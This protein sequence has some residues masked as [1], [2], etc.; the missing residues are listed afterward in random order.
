MPKGLRSFD[1][2]DA[3]FFL[4][5]L[6]GPTD[7]EG[8]P[9]SIR[10]W[11]TRLEQTDADATCAVGLVYGPSGCGKS[12]LFKAGV[13]PRLAPHVLVVYLE[14]TPD[15]TEARLLK[16]LRKVCGA[17]CGVGVPPAGSEEADRMPAPQ[18]KKTGIF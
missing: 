15:D 13:L 16:A 14:A 2:H 5:L 18:G 12:S 7:R 11:K 3:D 17:A 10:F 1:A 6:P 4:Q 8:L 9:E